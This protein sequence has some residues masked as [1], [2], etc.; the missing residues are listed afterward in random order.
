MS[1]ARLRSMITYAGG[2]DTKRRLQIRNG[3]AKEI[4]A[5]AKM[6]IR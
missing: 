1:G 4:S 2:S 3:R 6:A 5:K